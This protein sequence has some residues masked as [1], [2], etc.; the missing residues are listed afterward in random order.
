MVTEPM[1]SESTT[2]AEMSTNRIQYVAEKMGM[3]VACRQRYMRSPPSSSRAAPSACV[4]F[5]AK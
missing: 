1:K 5:F 4:S 2:S 3:S